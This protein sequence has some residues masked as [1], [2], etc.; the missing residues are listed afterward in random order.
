MRGSILSFQSQLCCKFLH[1]NAKP[2]GQVGCFPWMSALF[3]L[4]FPLLFQ[5]ICYQ[6]HG[7]LFLIA[8]CNHQNTQFGWIRIVFRMMTTSYFSIN[9][10]SLD[11][12]R[13]FSQCCLAGTTPAREG[14][15]GFGSRGRLRLEG[16]TPAQG[17]GSGSSA[18]RLGRRRALARGEGE[19]GQLR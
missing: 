14:G 19:G 3:L 12:I 5:P 11:L 6:H 2:D 10:G 9:S 7:T 13:M 1:G 4:H 18:A 8:L 16:T 17:T 15:A